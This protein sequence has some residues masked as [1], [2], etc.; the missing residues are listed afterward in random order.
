MKSPEVSI[1]VP[2]FNTEKYLPRCIDNILI[3]TFTNFECIL[4][5]D[6]S[7]DNSLTICKQY[8]QSDSRIVLLHQ[9][10]S[11]VS[12]S[13]NRGIELARGKYVCFVDSDDIAEKNFCE[14]LFTAINSANTDVACCGYFENS[15]SYIL[16]CKDIIFNNSNIIEIIH[17]LE[18]RQ[19][20]G[21]IWNKIYKKSILDTFTLRF[22]KLITFGED[23]LF[24]MQ[25]FRHVKTAYVCS[26]QLYHY[27][28]DNQLALTKG[29]M[30]FSE[31]NFRFETVSNT[32]RELDNNNKSIFYAELLAKD[33]IYTIALLLRLY[34]EKKGIK[35]RVGVI[36]NLK[37]FYNENRAE[38]KFRTGVVAITY[39]ILLYVPSRI[40]D[41]IFYIIY[42][43]YVALVK[44]GKAKVRF[45]EN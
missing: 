9:E 35:E 30:T 15:K 7:T 38:N 19:A 28:H 22:S 8:S 20:F 10:N 25:Y 13:R 14:K 11:G 40:F 31:M 6:G 26:D 3:Q 43:A 17:Y 27:K 39:K 29:K 1:I 16:C 32:L 36:S 23:M 21:V 37:K 24:N 45:I 44:I 4:I 33:F 34:S 18:M 2:I 42:L 12:E 41:I 5:D